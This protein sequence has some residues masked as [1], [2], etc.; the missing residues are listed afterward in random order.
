MF[1]LSHS[2][3]EQR[4]E[5]RTATLTSKGLQSLLSNIIQLKK[6]RI[7]FSWLEKEDNKEWNEIAL[8]DSTYQS[9]TPKYG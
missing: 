4:T 6:K 8:C 7:K 9:Q 1:I 3:Y 2:L 5:T